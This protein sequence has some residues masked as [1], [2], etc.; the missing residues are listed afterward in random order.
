MILMEMIFGGQGVALS[1]EMLL[2]HVEERWRSV[3]EV[4]SSALKRMFRKGNCEKKD[5]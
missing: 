2:S 3:S 1:A 5:I 4:D